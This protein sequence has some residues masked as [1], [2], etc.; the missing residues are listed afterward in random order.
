MK[1][2]VSQIRSMES[3]FSRRDQVEVQISGLG[4]VDNLDHLG[5]EN[6]TSKMSRTEKA[7]TLEH[8]RKTKPTNHM[9]RRRKTKAKSTENI[10]KKILR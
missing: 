3:L 4:K 5:K 10:F 1:N 8:Y 6:V 9:G 7:E 2:S